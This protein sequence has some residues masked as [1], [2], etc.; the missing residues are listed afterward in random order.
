MFSSFPGGWRKLDPVECR[1]PW[2]SIKSC[3]GHRTSMWASNLNQGGGDE[4]GFCDA[5][6]VGNGIFRKSHAVY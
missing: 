2:L 4:T 6:I 5:S 3:G 1:S